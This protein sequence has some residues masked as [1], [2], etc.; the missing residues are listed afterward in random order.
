MA[1]RRHRPHLRARREH[2]RPRDAAPA[3]PVPEVLAGAVA[4]DPVTNFYRRYWDFRARTEDA[5]P[6]GARPLRGSEERRRRTRPRTSRGA[7]HTGSPRSRSRAFRC[8]LW[9]SL[10]DQIILDQVHQTA[11][12]YEQLRKLAEGEGGRRDRALEPLHPDA[13]A[14]PDRAPLSRPAR[15]S[16]DGAIADEHVGV[17]ARLI[18][19]PRPRPGRGAD[20]RRS[21]VAS[22]PSRDAERGGTSRSRR[23]GRSGCRRMQPL[24]GRF[25]SVPGA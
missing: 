8:R 16:S 24:A 20:S 14:D 11:H 12:F 3:R 22:C 1:A 2:G 7:P 18:P 23:S 19:S 10:A 21:A 4:M 13:P 6:P 15:L 25:W 17:V 9:W 5:R